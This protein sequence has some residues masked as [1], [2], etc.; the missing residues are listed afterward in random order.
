[1]DNL[2]GQEPG[3]WVCF[4][5]L[6]SSGGGV[7]LKPALSSKKVPAGVRSPLL[8]SACAFVAVPQKV[9]SGQKENLNDN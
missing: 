8:T 9:S 2:E 3:K 5:S 7:I 6:T 1:M 4:T